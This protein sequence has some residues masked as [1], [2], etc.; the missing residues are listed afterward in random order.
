MAL[1]PRG[2]PKPA[3]TDPFANGW[4]AIAD[5]ADA[6]DA[7]LAAQLPAAGAGEPTIRTGGVVI[8]L[9]AVASWMRWRKVGGWVHLA[10]C[11]K[12]AAAGAAG[13]L[14]VDLPIAA[15]IEAG[16][17]VLP[18][19]SAS[20]LNAGAPN[21]QVGQAVVELG[22][23]R[24]GVYVQAGVDMYAVALPTASHYLGQLLYEAA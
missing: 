6:V 22:T 20:V 3:A 17:A 24:V 23:G 21:F 10:F 15:R 5:L 1:T 9:D 12:T 11:A 14:T 13:R 18:V 2:Y 7:D 16:G 8:A 4:D 19:G